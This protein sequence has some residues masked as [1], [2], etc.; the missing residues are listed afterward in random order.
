MEKKEQLLIIEPSSE[1]KFRGPFNSS[2]TSHMKLINPT[3]KKILFKIKTTA[4]KKYCVRPN[5]GEL[6]GKGVIEVAICLQPFIFDPN[7]K[8][9]HKF[10]VQSLVAPE[11]DINIEQLWK[12]VNPDALMDY[13]LRCV[14]ELPV[15]NSTL[16][17]SAALISNESSSDAVYS[18]DEKALKS[19]PYSKPMGENNEYAKADTEMRQL[20]DE[21]SQLR[22]ENMELKEQVLRLRMSAESSA[23]EKQLASEYNNPYKPPQ[24]TEQFPMMYLVIIGILIALFSGFIAKVFL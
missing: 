18:G 11:G 9:K 19:S 13:K 17:S 4:P 24:S 2:V 22:Q 7:E 3:D 1:L 21:G 12:D 14:F 20:R 15:E 5:C 6:E 23:K 10:M 8:N 16:P